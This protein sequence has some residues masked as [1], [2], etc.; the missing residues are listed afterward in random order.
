MFKPFEHF[1]HVTVEPS[2]F[3]FL[4]VYN[5]MEGLDTNLFLQKACRFNST[6]EPDL[7]TRCDDE[8]RGILFVTEVGLK[9]HPIVNI[10]ALLTAIFA[11]YWSDEA[12]RRRRPLIYI[13]IMGQIFHGLSGCLHSY[14]WQWQPITAVITLE[15][16][17]GLY[18]DVFIMILACQ[19]YVCD[20]SGK[21]SRTMRLGILGTFRIL[22]IV[23]GRGG[24]GFILHNFGFFYTYFFCFVLSAGG[25]LCGLIFIKDTSVPVE[26]KMS[27][28]NVFNLKRVIFDSF[29]VVFNRNLGRKR[30]TVSM[31][32]IANVTVNF[33]YFGELSV[34]YSYLRYRFGWNEQKYSE[35]V[36]FRL[37][38]SSLGILFC[39][40]V[41]SRWLKIHDGLIGILAGSFDTI[42]IVVLLF[43]D[44]IWQLYLIPVIDIFHGTAVTIGTSFVSKYYDINELGRLNAV[45]CVFSLMASPTYSAYNAIFQKTLDTYP[46]AFCLLS[47][48]VDIIIV[49]C[50]CGSYYF[51]KK[52]DILREIHK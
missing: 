50:F 15:A 36:F 34:L 44:Q 11:T 23:L 32:M 17:K 38:L 2:F 7:N 47:V 30:V 21:E 26:K 51:S 52:L 20:I 43:A 19:L 46:S 8:R 10:I 22:A 24:S 5:W 41:L 4:I 9:Y 12:G 42:A 27:F 49:L 25:L 45:S 3:I 40:V 29:K 35:F 39:S 18:A 31:L 48:G 1:K 16:L 37:S 13:P 14:F 33:T 6:S 28:C